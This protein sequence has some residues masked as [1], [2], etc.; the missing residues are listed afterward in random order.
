MPV[1]PIKTGLHNGKISLH[2]DEFAT[3]PLIV[4]FP[5]FTSLSKATP[6]HPS[7]LTLTLNAL[8]GMNLHAYST[9]AMFHKLDRRLPLLTFKTYALGAFVLQESPRLMHFGLSF[10]TLVKLPHLHHQQTVLTTKRSYFLKK[11]E[12]VQNLESRKPLIFLLCQ[13]TKSF[14]LASNKHLKTF[15]NLSLDSK[16]MK[17]FRLETALTS[18]TTNQ[19]VMN[20]GKPRSIT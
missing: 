9:N 6:D 17:Y 16:K 19:N 18:C 3:F 10:V 15:K 5:M 13:D 11:H 14:V 20:Q 12:K 4:N 8:Y 1:L 7:N 2:F